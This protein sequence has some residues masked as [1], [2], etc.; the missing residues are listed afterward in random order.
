[1]GRSAAP[2]L[3]AQQRPQMGRRPARGQGAVR[4]PGAGAVRGSAGSGKSLTDMARVMVFPRLQR[5][6]FSTLSRVRDLYFRGLAMHRAQP[7]TLPWLSSLLA[8][9]GGRVGKQED[10]KKTS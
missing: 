8:E 1:P 2:S 10:I 7:V 9:T 6:P 5:R 4:A 3:A